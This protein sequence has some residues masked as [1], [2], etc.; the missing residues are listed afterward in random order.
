MQRPARHPNDV[1]AWDFLFSRDEAGRLIKWLVLVDEYSR[2][3][4]ILEP[5]RN[6]PASVLR[7][8]FMEVINERGVP[9]IVRSDNGPEFVEKKL[10]EFLTLIG[11]GSS[12][13]EPGAPWENGFAESFNSRVRD[14]FL[15]IYPI[16]DLNEAKIAAARWNDHYNLDRPHSSLGDLTPAEFR[17]AWGSLERLWG[18]RRRRGAR[19][20]AL[21]KSWFC[22]HREWIN[23]GAF[24]MTLCAKL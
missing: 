22:S 14:Q 20:G 23:F 3:C 9:S 4:L 21:A 6:L 17:D 12:F 18:S 15:N 16:A 2:E 7:E 1:W 8:L 5:A 11:S 24:H 19:R 10:K 13:I